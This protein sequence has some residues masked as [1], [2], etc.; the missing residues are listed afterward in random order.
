MTLPRLSHML[1]VLSKADVSVSN[2]LEYHDGGEVGYAFV[3]LFIQSFVLG[4]RQTPS[5]VEIC[6]C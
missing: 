2:K 5:S 4:G 3:H 1:Y 6:S